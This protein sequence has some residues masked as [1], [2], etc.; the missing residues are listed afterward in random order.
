MI[1]AGSVQFA[2]R[3]GED[4]SAGARIAKFKADREAAV[5]FTLDDGWE[6]NATL[7]VPLFDKHGIH[8]T[9]FLVPGQI[10]EDDAPKST[11]NYGKVPWS[12]WKKVAQS[13]HE[14]GNHTLHHPGLTKAD[15]KTV[16]TEINGAYERILEKVGVAPVS[17]AYPGNARD[18]RVRKFVYAKHAVARETE[19][20]YGGKD[21]TTEKANALVDR[22]LKD[23]R[24]MVAMLHAIENGYAAF[25][26]ASVLDEHLKYVQSLKNRLWVDTFGNV[27]RYVK[28]RDAAKLDAKK[29]DTSVSFTLT[30]DLDAKLFCVPLTIVIDAKGA[31]SAEAKRDGAA[32]PVIVEADRIV[33]DV[34]PGPSPVTVTWRR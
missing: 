33:L 19:T 29:S 32:L 25:P 34:V 6:D 10:P 3:A 20:G 21:F 17:F 1:G 24:W 9:F 2:G 22:T 16:E 30:T 5:S 7:A 28:E 15:D 11:H 26:S 4:V 14:I 23:K 31:A 13:G 8:A 18:D 27:G 12:T